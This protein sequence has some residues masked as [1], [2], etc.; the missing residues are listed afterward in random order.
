MCVA[1]IL[2]PPTCL[3]M[4]YRSVVLVTTLSCAEAVDTPMIG[5]GDRSAVANAN[6]VNSRWVPI[7]YSWAPA[8]PTML[9][10]V[11]LVRSERERSLQEDAIGRGALCRRVPLIT[12]H[13]LRELTREELQ[14]PRNRRRRS[15]F[16]GIILERV[17]AAA[18]EPAPRELIARECIRAG[19]VAIGPAISH[20]GRRDII[21]HNETR[22]ALVQLLHELGLQ[23]ERLVEPL[24]ERT[25]AIREVR[26]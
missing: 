12:G 26:P 18:D 7:K 15:P 2:F 4:S 22:I 21:G 8:A 13:Q 14:V 11:R 24:L 23:D 3:A 16:G 6:V 5:A 9:E 25:P 17:E 1:V 19:E 10:W 20:I